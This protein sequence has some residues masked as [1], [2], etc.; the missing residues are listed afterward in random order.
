[1]NMNRNPTKV[2]SCG[3]VTWRSAENGTI[4]IVLIKQF[5]DINSWGIP[6]GKIKNYETL[7]ECAIRETREEAGIDVA[8]CIKL[9][10]VFKKNAHEHRVVVP[11]IAVQTDNGELN[12]QDPDSEVAEARW[13]NENSLPRMHNYQ[14]EMILNSVKTIKNLIEKNGEEW[15]KSERFID[16]KLISEVHEKIDFTLKI[17]GKGTEWKEFRKH[18][19]WNSTQTIRRQFKSTMTPFEQHVKDYW[20]DQRSC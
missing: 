20:E 15:L 8:L 16:P 18:L 9:T 1:M 13:F 7:E 11:Y 14:R 6:K 4:E 3:T 5:D 10:P 12:S 2:V 17:V 19:L